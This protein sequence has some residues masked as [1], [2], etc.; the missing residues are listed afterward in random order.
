MVA[1]C[2]FLFSPRQLHSRRIL[3]SER[4]SGT[5]F[6]LPWSL[7][8]AW[9][10][11]TGSCQQFL[12]HA[13]TTNSEMEAAFD[14]SPDVSNALRD[15]FRSRIQEVLKSGSTARSVLTW[16]RVVHHDV[17]SSSLRC[18]CVGGRARVLHDPWFARIEECTLQV[19][20]AFAFRGWRD[21]RW[22]ARPTGMRVAAACFPGMCSGLL[23]PARFPISGRCPLAAALPRGA[24]GAVA[25]GHVGGG[26][27]VDPGPPRLAPD[28][29]PA[30]AGRDARPQRVPE[31]LASKNTERSVLPGSPRAKHNP[32]S[33]S[34]STCVGERA[35]ALRGP[36][37][38]SYWRVHARGVHRVFRSRIA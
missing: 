27:D 33:C 38:R 16:R 9:Q 3:S 6:R 28:I 34:L 17:A 2:R 4:H 32:A 26:R 30:S 5:T 25:V 12:Q 7:V 31:V 11:R 20:A 10:L 14:A 19:F 15:T 13:T 23:T 18:T 37:V 29:V 21:Q 36:P 1:P 35:R 22:A 8:F 24:V